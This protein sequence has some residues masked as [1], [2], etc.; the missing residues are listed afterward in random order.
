MT[1]LLPSQKQALADA[2]DRSGIPLDEFEV[3]SVDGDWVGL[4]DDTTSAFRH[5][6][7]GFTWAFFYMPDFVD[8]VFGRRVKGG[9]A[10]AF[11]PG[12]STIH[13]QRLQLGWDEELA[14]FRHW[15]GLVKRE[16][17]VLTPGKYQ[18]RDAFSSSPEP[19]RPSVKL[20]PERISATVGATAESP[21]LEGVS[22]GPV[23]PTIN[24]WL[25]GERK[26][27][28]LFWLVVATIIGLALA[29]AAVF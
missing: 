25:E 1:D 7:T 10:C 18:S 4:I 5:K 12:T 27:R 13:E 22:R 3:V 9:Y 6:P 19:E 26:K 28:G 24:T 29:A 16:V 23:W 8:D 2:I 17:N 14:A 21:A 15:L 20:E 11:K